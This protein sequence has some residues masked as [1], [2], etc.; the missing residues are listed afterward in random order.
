MGDDDDSWNDDLRNPPFY[1]PERASPTFNQ[2]F[3]A[4]WDLILTRTTKMGIFA[5]EASGSS[6]KDVFDMKMPAFACNDDDASVISEE[7]YLVSPKF[8]AYLKWLI[9]TAAFKKPL[10]DPRGAEHVQFYHDWTR[11][12]A[13]KEDIFRKKLLEALEI[14][15]ARFPPSKKRGR[16]LLAARPRAS[17]GGAPLDDPEDEEPAR[18][19]GAGPPA[20]GAERSG[21]TSSSATARPATSS[22]QSR[23]YAFLPCV[24]LPRGNPE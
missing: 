14:W 15:Y 3:A 6:L 18:G 12:F 4:L 11:T 9:Y 20:G 24:D 8:I 2:L 7:R 22:S 13:G 21:A 16:S 17:V 19:A 5:P 10:G 23:V 1:D